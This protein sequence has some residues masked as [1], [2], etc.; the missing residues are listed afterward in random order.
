MVLYNG[1]PLPNADMNSG[2]HN[3]LGKTDKEGV[4]K[5]PVIAG[6]NLLSVEHKEKIKDD[7]DADVL[8]ETATLTFEVKK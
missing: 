2:E 1:T 7:P 8:D 4:I 5:V 3:A 6:V